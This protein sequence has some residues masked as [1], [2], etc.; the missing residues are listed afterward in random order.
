[1]KIKFLAIFCLV[2]IFACNTNNKNTADKETL[3]AQIMQAEKD[4]EKMAAEKG[5]PEAFSFFADSNAVIHRGN[6]LLKG[7][8]EIKEHYEG[9]NFD[10]V[11][12]KWTADFVDVASSGDLGYT[13]GNYTWSFTDSTGKNTEDKGIFHTVWKKQADGSWKYTWD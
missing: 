6:K 13:Y 11:S 10:N 8:L 7:K 3:K 4:F 9:S 2:L 12:V 5:I 1:M